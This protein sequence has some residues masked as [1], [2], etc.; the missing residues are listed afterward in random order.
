MKWISVK[1]SKPPHNTC[2]LVSVCYRQSNINKRFVC[3]AFQ[4]NDIWYDE[5]EGDPLL[6]KDSFVSHWMPL[7]TQ[8][9]D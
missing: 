8:P 6:T 1:E 3:V 2:V 5:H 4:I 9:E 7:P